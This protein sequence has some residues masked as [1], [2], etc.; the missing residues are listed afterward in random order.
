MGPL[1]VLLIL[2]A[3]GAR[4]DL[5]DPFPSPSGEDVV[6]CFRGDLWTASAD[7]G[8]MRCIASGESLEYSPC[9]SPD[10]R[11]VAFTSDR[12][13]SGDVYVMDARG[14]VS[15]QLTFHAW[16]DL[17]LCFSA[18]SDS[19]YFLSSR[20]GG[21][22]WVWSVPV[23]GGTPVPKARV[24]TLNACVL[25]GGALALERGFTPWW[26]MHYSGSASS[27][28]W[29]GSGEVWTEAAATARDE[30]WPM[31]SPAVDALLFVM[32]DS[33]GNGAIWSLDGGG[34]PVQRTFL[35]DGDATF[36]AI[37]ADGGTVVFEHDGGLMAMDV[38]GWTVRSID[39]EPAADYAFP[40]EYGDMVGYSTDYLAVDTSGSRMAVSALGRLFAGTA[41]DG[42]I[43]DMVEVGTDGAGAMDPVWSPD[44]T[45]LA[46]CLEHDGRVDL[47]VASPFGSDTV[48]SDGPLPEVRVLE[49]ASTVARVPRWAP[50]GNRISYLDRDGV[51]RVLDCRTLADIEVCPTRDVIHHSWSPD[52]RWLAFSV[53][54]LAHREDVF[55]VPSGGGDPVNVSRHPNDDFQPFWPSDGRRLLF[56]SRTDEGAYSI[57]QVWLRR[58]DWDLDQEER[59]ELLD[60]PAG[61]VEIE[62]EGLQHRT[63]TLCTVTGYYDFY[64]ASPDGRLIAFPAWDESDRMDLWSVDW[65]GGST[66]RLTWSGESPSQIQVASDGTIFYVAI[67]G[68]VRSAVSPGGVLDT[69]GWRMPVWISVAGMQAQK[70]DEAWRLLRDN[71]Y[72][73]SMH[74]V[75]WDAIRSEYRDRAVSSVVD[76]DFNDVVRRMLGELSA[77]HLGIWGPGGGS[78]SP[79]SGTLGFF[80][81][82]DWEG[83]GIRVDSIVPYSPADD[84]ATGLEVGDLVLSIQGMPVGPSDNLYR[85]LLQR[86]GLETLVTVRRGGRTFDLTMEPISEWTLSALLYDEWIARNRRTVARLTGGRVG[87]LHVPSMD[88]SSVET[89]V[90]DLFA[91]GLDRDAL[92]IDVRNNGG[93]STHDQI[94]REISRPEY[95]YSVDRSGAATLEPLG[96]WQKPIA[97]LINERC[98]SDG[99]IFPAAWQE[100]DLGPIVG[101]ATFGAVIG[102][103][104]VPLID[105]TMFR[106][107]STG[108]YTLDGRNLENSG[109]VP[110]V[111]VEERPEDAGLGID[112]QL[113]AA[114]LILL[115]E[116]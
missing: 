21:D 49:T 38:P 3:S 71:F 111:P 66:E 73:E 98:Y 75:D 28:I 96:V 85:A 47:A 70:F 55:I 88:Q 51:L 22:G 91:E 103:V 69:F 109:V 116:I 95:A 72:D 33:S 77:S 20:E 115:G 30:R 104:D 45:R 24:S 12:T 39:P 79:S 108:W 15:T 65:K 113:E 84:G 89:F 5:R 80:P 18:G 100:L 29:T 4:S 83:P 114:A 25:P 27:D 107:P 35:E 82:H 41:G 34:D 102:T 57:R 52:G 99:E 7:G 13:G 54:V 67:G 92:I 44:G 63:E 81:D 101:E 61:V 46:F 110:D 59:E 42:G 58:E 16:E 6:L 43:E 68:T 76:E 14:G 53:P 106:L 56:A 23:S 26:R 11:L 86:T 19:V 94:L 2:L 74:G 87:Y 78:W 112:R 60:Q 50:D 17:A 90:S 8:P 62:W 93:G 97:L 36:P 1:Q 10:G 105:G 64:G 48:L 31:Y 9:W 40:V 37:S 32:E